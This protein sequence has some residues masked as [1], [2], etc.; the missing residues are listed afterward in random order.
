[1]K[2]KAK[3]FFT[4]TNS[5]LVFALFAV[6]VAYTFITGNDPFVFPSTANPINYAYMMFIAFAQN[7]S[8]SMVSRARNRDS[9]M[10]HMVAAW[11]S[12]GVWFATFA[13]L[14]YFKLNWMLFVPYTCGTVAGSLTGTQIS[15]WIERILGATSDSH[16]AKKAPSYIEIRDRATGETRL[17]EVE[18]GRIQS[19]RTPIY[20][21]RTEKS[22]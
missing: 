1:M 22:V 11:C 4:N 15:M 8:F 12:N 10:Y 13:Y 17:I 21:R 9:I 18:N 5:L 6:G 20:L 19:Y 14:V 2:E 16:V 3:A 7:V